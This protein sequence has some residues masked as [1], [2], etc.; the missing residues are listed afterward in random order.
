MH[1]HREY[2]KTLIKPLESP[3]CKPRLQLNVS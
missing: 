3:L 2:F 1:I